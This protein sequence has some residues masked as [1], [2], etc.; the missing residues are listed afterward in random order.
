MLLGVLQGL[1]EQA[2][3]RIPGRL[4]DADLALVDIDDPDDGDEGVG[5]TRDREPACQGGE[6]DA[7][8]GRAEGDE[9]VE[10]R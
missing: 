6:R 8:E 5:Q 3:G 10:D 9:E 1:D 7:G 2:G 4:E